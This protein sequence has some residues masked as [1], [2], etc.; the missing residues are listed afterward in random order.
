MRFCTPRA[1]PGFALS[2]IAVVASV[3]LGCGKTASKEAG[4][5]NPP[6]RSNNTE[7][8][9]ADACSPKKLGVPDGK[10]VQSWSPPEGCQLKP[11]TMTKIFT[12][13]A[14]A[15]DMFTCAEGVTLGIDFAANSLLIAHRTLSPAS[16]GFFMLDDTTVITFV[17]NQRT[18]CE[19]ERPPMPVTLPLLGLLPA[20]AERG[21][22]EATCRVELAC[23]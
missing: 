6:V 2:F 9:A 14:Q 11:S 22:L 21:S 1:L 20:G 4:T 10:P 19:G 5:S 15:L 16:T 12:N 3:A 7:P 13:E 8:P 18:P 23:P 17:D